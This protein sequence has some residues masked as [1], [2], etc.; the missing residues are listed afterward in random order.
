MNHEIHSLRIPPHSEEAERGVLGSILLDPAPGM[1][2]AI[3]AGLNPDDFYD[4]RC[5]TLF[6]QMREMYSARARH[7][8]A[9]TIAEWLKDN[10]ALDK[11]GGYDH[12]IELQDSTIVPAHLEYYA[13][14]VQEKALR[15]RIIAQSHETLDRAY[16]NNS[17][18]SGVLC[19]ARS[20]LMALDSLAGSSAQTNEQAANDI[21]SGWEEIRDGARNG[22]PWHVT[23]IGNVFGHFLATGN[24]YFIAAEPG[25]GKSVCLQNLFTKWAINMQQP[26]AIASIEMTHKKFIA[27]LLAERADVSAWGLDNG[28]YGGGTSEQRKATATRWIEKARHAKDL[29]CNAPL[30]ISDRYMN[31]DSVCS[32][33]LEMYE[34]HGIKAF[35]IDYFQ[36]LNPPS[37][38]KYEGIEAVRYNCGKLLEFSKN[39]GVITIALSQ[40]TKLPTNANG[41]PRD[42]RQ[43]DLFG[44]R[45]IDAHSEGT[46]IFFNRDSNDFASIVK[47]RNGGCGRVPVQ[48]NRARLRFEDTQA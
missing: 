14:I 10:D 17:N 30:H 28:K 22:L 12:L 16:S 4:R 19:E 27:R 7:M 9:I 46:V 48:F 41:Q 43:D 38:K 25:G 32:Y 13:E 36:L 33:G 42:P 3:K 35:G 39:T 45:I 8:D 29:I 31:T 44:G 23:S 5:Q 47:N 24:P 20:N 37:H 11:A 34:R 1:I 18:A 21:I 6:Q 2:K 40:I 26:C 15:R